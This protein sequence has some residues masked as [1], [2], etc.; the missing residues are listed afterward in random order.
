MAALKKALKSSLNDL[1]LAHQNPRVYL[2]NYF[3]EFRN[4]IDRECQV[5]L[6]ME[7]NLESKRSSQAFE[8]QDSIINQVNVFEK[9]CLNNIPKNLLNSDLSAKLEATISSV[10]SKLENV[11]TLKED[12]L[13]EIFELIL[14]ASILVQAELFTNR[15]I[16]FV[17]TSTNRKIASFGFLLVIDNTYVSQ[18]IMD[19]DR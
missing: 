13:Y 17:N 18:Y 4:K 1:K 14:N 11:D 19:S 8:C 3:T 7:T 6:K 15:G 2:S 9:A 12:G 10:E 5:F 16:I